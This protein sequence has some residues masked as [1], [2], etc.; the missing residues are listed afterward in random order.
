MEN[1]QPIWFSYLQVF[2]RWRKFY[3]ISVL[4]VGVVAAII[5]L[6][7]PKYYQSTATILP[8]L[9]TPGIETLIPEEVRGFLGGFLSENNEANIYLAIIKSRSIR[10]KMIDKFELDKVYRFKKPYPIEDLLN[11]LDKN[12]KIEFDGVNPLKVSVIDRDPER[13]AAMVNY[14]TDE[15]DK[16][17]QE[18]NNRR[19][20]YNRQFLE[21]RVTETRTTLAEYEDSL[22]NFQ[23]ANQ[24]ISLPDQAKASI[25]V[26]S[27]LIAK[28]MA[29]DVQIQVL[30]A[31]VEPNYPQLR[32]L[33]EEK[34]GI[35]NQIAKLTQAS[36]KETTDIV[37]LPSFN[38]LPE[39]GMIYLRLYREVE[40]QSKLLEYLIPQYEQARIQEVRDTPTVTI[41]DQGRV[42]TKRIKPQRKII[43]IIS[44]ILA[45][46]ISTAFVF[47]SEF[48]FRIKKDQ[49]ETYQSLIQM[50]NQ[51]KNMIPFIKKTN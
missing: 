7:L 26:A 29:L 27:N 24:A 50:R 38:E 45:F 43:V 8:P 3:I 40:I 32:M 9:N 22:K 46:I 28:M 39:L 30:K 19:A 13:V 42:P 1:N 51:L 48:L 41:L 2:F 15:L 23:E 16:M 49:P 20:F 37:P 31:S 5:S 10:E 33:I 17:Y 4:G 47:S 18:I 44:M 6:L 35:E 11:V 21:K 34:K 12:I 14:M 25:D 36:P